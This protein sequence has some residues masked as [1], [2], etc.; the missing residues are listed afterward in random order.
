MKLFR[1]IPAVPWW[2]LFRLLRLERHEPD[3]S[4][5]WEDAVDGPT[6]RFALIIGWLFWVVLAGVTVFVVKLL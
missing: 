4:W 2:L 3:Y 1:I 6:T 5:N